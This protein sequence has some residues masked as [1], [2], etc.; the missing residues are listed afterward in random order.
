M[1]RELSSPLSA[2]SA[3]L[4][5]SLPQMST[6]II[7]LSLQ[8]T[9]KVFAS[10]AAGVSSS[11]SR[12]LH[13]ETKNLVTSIKAGLAPFSSV[14]TMDVQERAHEFLQ[15]LSFVEADLRN[16]RPPTKPLSSSFE[17]IEMDSGFAESSRAEDG[18]PI[19]PKSLFLFKPL[20]EGFEMN[21]V[22]HR[23]QQ[24]VK[25]PEDVNFEAEIVP[26][27]GFVMEAEEVDSE[28]EKRK[29]TFDLGEGGGA[30]MEELRRV[31]REQEGEKKKRKGKGKAKEGELTAEERE[32]KQRRKEEKRRRQKE[33]PYYLG[34]KEDIEDIPIVKLD[35]ED[36]LDGESCA[37]TEV[38]V[39]SQTSVN[40]TKPNLS[41]P[42][43]LQ[44][45]DR[46]SIKLERCPMALQTLLHLSQYQSPQPQAWRA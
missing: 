45:L 41:V 1:P 38:D 32:A 11:W 12:D 33:D 31:L 26:G 29:E 16:H 23:A 14:N 7:T 5:P 6:R 28:D 18:E 2:I 19:Y 43:H 8:A 39:D 10:R 27:G 21:A 40:L 36:G 3:L 42:L 9:A 24:A 22:A 25:L 44:N 30:G 20:F 4:S 37:S 17:G 13:E 34:E 15:L 46:L 35:L